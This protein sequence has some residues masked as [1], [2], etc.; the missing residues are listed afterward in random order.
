[1]PI[2][3]T[4]AGSTL[5]FVAND[6]MYGRELWRSDGTAADT[7]RLTDLI[8]YNEL[9][10]GP[11]NLTAMGS[12]LFFATP[13]SLWK[14]DSTAAGTT[15]LTNFSS[16]AAPTGLSWGLEPPSVG[17][18][19]V[20]GST[21]FFVVARNQ[22]GNWQLWKSDGTA[23]GTTLVTGMQFHETP[24]PAGP[25]NLTAV[26]DT[27]FF[28]TDDRVHGLELWKSDGTAAG[29]TLVKDINPNGDSWPTDLTAVGSAL[30]FSAS[31]GTT[32]GLW[33]SDGTAAGTTLVKNI[34]PREL[35]AVGNRLFFAAN[36]MYGWELWKSDGTESGTTMVKDINPTGWS[37]PDH[38]AAVGSTL[39]F[40][41]DDGVHGRELW[42][43]NGTAAGTRL[44][45]DLN[46]GAASADPSQFTRV[47]TTVFF[48]AQTPAT[49]KELWAMD[50]YE[51][52]LPLTR[53]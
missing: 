29:T 47:G 33:K 35:T 27:L 45:Q 38:L 49:G 40:S 19:T 1:V 2:D 5:F 41:A 21:L 42:T 36:F 6:C 17:S 50:Y 37:E 15:R 7:I 23:A 30:L 12:I 22:V 20:V 32:G 48:S 28:S 46:P 53:R 9:D 13:G 8:P 43:S 34:A 4:A 39:Y 44:V 3:L 31:D 14:S 18:L 52:Y 51:V 24:F 10:L 25:S 26:G 11:S 16:I